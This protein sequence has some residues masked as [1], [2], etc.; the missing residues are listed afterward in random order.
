MEKLNF[1]KHQLFESIKNITPESTAKW[2][3]MNAHQMLEHLS[4]FFDVSYEKIIFPLA[5]PEEHLPTYK[6]FLYSDKAFRENTK[7]PESVLGE[8]PMPY[9]FSTMEEAK[10]NLHQSVNKF[11]KYFKEH[12]NKTTLHP[13]FGLLNFEEWVML[14]HKH[15][16]HHLKQFGILE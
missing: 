2:G 11:V 12:P 3:V 8:K 13:A 1:L 10:T 6:A 7:A 9:R 14:H 5:V 15:V 16:V 4:D